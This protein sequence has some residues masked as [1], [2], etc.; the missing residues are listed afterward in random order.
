MGA[1]FREAPGGPEAVFAVAAQKDRGIE[2]KGIAMSG[3]N[4]VKYNGYPDADMQVLG[5]AEHVGHIIVTWDGTTW[6][7]PIPNAAI[8]LN[9]QITHWMDL[10]EEPGGMTGS[11]WLGF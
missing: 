1:K 8:F 7:A 9:Q 10:C 4:V 5:W 2:S 6:L 3:W 11:D